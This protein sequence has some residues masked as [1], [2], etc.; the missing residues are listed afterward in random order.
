[1]AERTAITLGGDLRVGRVAYGAMRLAG[2]QLWGEHPDRDGGIALLRQAVE[3]GVN[4]IDT[5]DVYGPH[6]NELLIREALHPYPE[7]LFIVSKV[8]A[9][10]DRQGAWHPAHGDGQAASRSAEAILALADRR[11]DT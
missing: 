2:T 7:D 10:R 9:V 1:M 8:G 11:R 6:T 5:A 3:G 4:L